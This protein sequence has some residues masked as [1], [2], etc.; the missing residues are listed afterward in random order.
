MLFCS[1][2]CFYLILFLSHSFQCFHSNVK[3]ALA[4]PSVCR[5]IASIDCPWP[6][7]FSLVCW[8]K[9]SP[10]RSTTPAQFLIPQKHSSDT[11]MGH[12]A[13]TSQCLY[14][15]RGNILPKAALHEKLYFPCK[16]HSSNPPCFN[17]YNSTWKVRTSRGAQTLRNPLVR[18][19]VGEDALEEGTA[20]HSSILTWRIPWADEPGR[21]QSMGSERVGHD[22]SDWTCTHV[23]EMSSP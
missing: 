14:Y 19:L 7:L 10:P 22:R 18:S 21:L 4:R 11:E 1:C 20:T 8:E 3:W 6:T 2:V 13:L 15:K 17:L 12:S 5:Q 16:H 23:P 9:P